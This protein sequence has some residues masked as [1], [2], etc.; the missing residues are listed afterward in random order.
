MIY[1][2]PYDGLMQ[3]HQHLARE[4]SRFLPVI[5]VEETASRIRR[6]LDGVPFDPALGAYK[7][8]LRVLSDNLWFYKSP[9]AVPRQT[10]YNRSTILSSIQLAKNLRPL[11]PPDKKVILWLPVPFGIGSIGLYDEVLSVMD[12]FDAYHLFP[13]LK[14]FAEPIRL[15]TIETAS[16][17]DLVIATNEELKNSLLDYN[18]NAHV[19]RNGCDPDHFAS[20][21][22]IPGKSSL[23]IDI[24]SLPKPVIGYMGDI[25]DWMDFDCMTALARKHPDW[26]VVL[27]G[28]W[29]RSEPPPREFPNMYFPGRVSYDQLPYYAGNF[30]VGTIPFMLNDL[31][32]VVNPLKLYEYFAMGIPVVATPL[33]EVTHHE[34]LV[35]I[36]ANPDE[37]VA[38]T[39]VAVREK[40][41]SPAREKRIR[42]AKANNWTSRA[43]DL[44]ILLEE[45]LA[46]KI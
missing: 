16:H 27:L 34:D 33:P 2:I 10:G 11:L 22:T 21:G 40:Y 17:V 14:G 45:N 23:V 3:R 9:P 6:L 37:F 28:T 24:K 44:K 12:Y 1:C 43:G 30:D 7:K 36:A 20:G 38:L 13:G 29:K 32:R 39:E 5:Y 41:D 4:F 25:A 35:Y 31:T 46:K 8:G 26:S 18:K 15:A 42:I 19:V